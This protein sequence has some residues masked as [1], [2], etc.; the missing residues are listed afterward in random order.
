MNGMTPFNWRQ[1]LINYPDLVRAG[2]KNENSA[3]AHYL[4][5]GKNELRTD[6][7]LEQQVTNN[8]QVM[9]RI[10]NDKVLKIF[11][12]TNVR[13][14]KNIIEWIDYHS[15]IGF[16]TILVVDHLSKIPISEVIKDI[17]F[18]CNV[19]VKRL[20]VDNTVIPEIKNYLLKKLVIPFMLENNCD[21]FIHLDGDEYFNLKNNFPDVNSFVNYVKNYNQIGI[22]WLMFGS[23][24]NNN[25]PT[26]N[27]LI[28]NYLRCTT[29]K[30]TFC[31]F[32][33]CLVDPKKI[34]I[35]SYNS[36][37]VN[38]HF[39]K[40][41]RG[42]SCTYAN[43]KLLGD[44]EINKCEMSGYLIND[45]VNINH[46]YYQSWTSY[47]RRKKI[48]VRD[49]RSGDAHP[50]FTKEEFHKLYNKQFDDTLST[51]YKKILI[52]NTNI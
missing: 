10:N 45:L 20:E 44:F 46:Y 1:Y 50:D 41:K 8:K 48:R 26:D 28:H 25:E 51:Y 35:D 4:K 13:D 9:P 19:I 30:E 27:S 36:K 16:H 42:Y 47:I 24:Y 32:I 7:P 52:N 49:D 2:I 12:S 18:K 15:R 21:M 33:K 11:L 29:G 39:W 14:E 17:T 37:R 31:N 34:D 40:L 23:N 22:R 3:F 6:I 43:K 5:Y 38:P